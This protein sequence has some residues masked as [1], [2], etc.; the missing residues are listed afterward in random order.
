ML[1]VACPQQA[2]PPRDALKGLV[3]GF[4]VRLHTHLPL[5]VPEEAHGD[6]VDGGEV[7]AYHRGQRRHILGVGRGDAG[8]GGLVWKLSGWGLGVAP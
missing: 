2:H 4:G 8:G 1:Q 6:G 5:I 7:R 3:N